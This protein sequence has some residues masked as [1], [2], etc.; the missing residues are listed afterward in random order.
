M[1]NS[2]RKK[3][4]LNKNQLNSWETLFQRMFMALLKYPNLVVVYKPGKDML[5]ADCLS[6]AQLREVEENDELSA[7]IHSITKFVCVSEDNYNFYREIM[8]RDEKY[9]R[10]CKYVEN[11][12]PPYHQLDDLSQ[13]F[14]KFKSELHV[15]NE[16]L[17]YGDRLVI[18]TKLQNKIAKWL[19]APHLGI[20]K[21]LSRGRMLYYW[22][23]MSTQIK[24]L[25]ESCVI[26]E[27][28]KRNNQKEPLSQEE[29]PKYA[30]ERVSMDLFEYAG[31]D[32]IAIFD[33]Y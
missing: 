18:P 31:H 32:F 25:V 13:K 29:T 30:Y 9:T 24:E 22:P 12:W 3:I 19:H 11:G 23:G 10:V 7:I 14:H 4:N 21:T 8:K 1:L 33:A 28:F 20:E 2:I 17:F 26:C 16:L 5:I 6:R 27:R 15:E